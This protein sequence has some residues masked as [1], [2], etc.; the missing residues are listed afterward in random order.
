[1]EEGLPAGLQGFN[2]LLFHSFRRWG[3]GARLHKSTDSL[4]SLTHI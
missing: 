2:F 4:Y 3:L 1:V